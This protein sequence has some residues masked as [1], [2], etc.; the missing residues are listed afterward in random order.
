M[1]YNPNWN[2]PQQQYRQ[3]PPRVPQ[4][5]RNNTKLVII[6]SVAGLL[7]IGGIF[8]VAIWAG[9]TFGSFVGNTSRA[10]KETTDGLDSAFFG[11]M[12]ESASDKSGRYYEIIEAINLDSTLSDS[13]KVKLTNN[14]NALRKKTDEVLDLI[15]LYG[16]GYN[17]T[18]PL[19][20]DT[21]TNKKL[22]Y[23][24]FIKTGRAAELKQTLID[25]R[26]KT[27]ADLPDPAQQ[28]KLVNI[29]NVYDNETAP[30]YLKETTSW[31]SSNFHRS[32]AGVRT[33]LNTIMR[34]VIS[35]ENAALDCYKLYVKKGRA[36][37][38][39]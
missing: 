23:A 29:I 21:V 37:G 18:L 12:M 39:G 4:P 9:R 14:L 8:Y 15:E 11:S 17:D 38:D 1:N 16:D 10:I 20:K 33:N 31:E 36:A 7:V 28:D 25:F 27:F 5:P 24:Y 19:K 30:A 26:D 32:A 22:A 2:N 34:Q 3:Q 6:L 35:F 13:E